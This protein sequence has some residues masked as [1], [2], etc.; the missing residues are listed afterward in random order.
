MIDFSSFEF[1]QLTTET[2]LLP[3]R[4]ADEDLN[5]FLVQDAKNYLNEMMA[6][7]YVYVDKT[8]QQIAAYFTLLNDKVAYDPNDKSIW[9][10]LNRKIHNNKR[11][12]SYP[13]VKIGRLAVGEDYAG[14][15]LGSKI[16]ESVKLWYAEGNRAGCRFLT[17]DAYADATDFYRKNDFDYFTT[18]DTFD[19]TRL[20]YFDLKPFRDNITNYKTN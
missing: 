16:I 17:V 10:R 4:C 3:F 19:S 11:R 9:N 14:M 18:L 2:P 6:V 5:N 8:K 7:T 20:M 15:G 12:R 13:S 1:C